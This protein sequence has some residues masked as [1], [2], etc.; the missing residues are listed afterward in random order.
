LE[1]LE[2]SHRHP[3]WTKGG[4]PQKGEQK[5][6]GEHGTGREVRDLGGQ[7]PLYVQKSNK[8]SKTHQDEL[9]KNRFDLKQPRNPKPPNTP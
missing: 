9:L 6:R 3:S 5:W 1:S 2:R 7:K 8:I 4:G